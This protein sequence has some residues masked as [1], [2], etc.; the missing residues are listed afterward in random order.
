MLDGSVIDASNVH[1]SKTPLPRVVMLDGS[2]I[3]ARDEQ[4]MNAQ[5]PIVVI[6]FG[7]VKV[8]MACQSRKAPF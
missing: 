2:V 6:V 8:W 7:R 3:D 5:S 1:V 4:P